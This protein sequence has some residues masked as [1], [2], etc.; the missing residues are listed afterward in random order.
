MYVEENKVES[1]ELQSIYHIE[2]AEEGDQGVDGRN[3]NDKK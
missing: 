3:R 2:F 1:K